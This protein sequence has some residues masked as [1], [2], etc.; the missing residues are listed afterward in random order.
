MSNV[1]TFADISVDT[2]DR[3][4][5][6]PENCVIQFSVSNIAIKQIKLTEIEIPISYYN[7]KNINPNFLTIDFDELDGVGERSAIILPAALV[8]GKVVGYTLDIFLTAIKAAL[9]LAGTYTYT[10]DHSI[11]TN[12]ITITSTGLFNIQF[13]SGTNKLSKIGSLLGYTNMDLSRQNS[14]EA[15]NTLNIDVNNII[16]LD[17]FEIRMPVGSYTGTEFTAAL[18]EILSSE[19]G[20]TF[21]VA[22]DSITNKITITSDTSPYI[23]YFGTGANAPISNIPNTLGFDQLDTN[24][25]MVHTGLN[26]INFAFENYLYL[27]SSTALGVDQGLITSNIRDNNTI[28]RIP[29]SEATDGITF[30][31]NTSQFQVDINNP[32]NIN[33]ID[34]QITFRNNQP[35]DFNGHNWSAKMRILY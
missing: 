17:A 24:S 23:L 31:T 2:R 28:A 3:I 4:S 6:T 18:A 15:P 34:F 20:Q 5:G 33:T 9:D 22:I 14:Y 27:K 12:K 30:Y 13:Q 29:I 26:V 10:V 21:T 16:D 8:G 1:N 25:S 19:G 32:L 35:V 11:I 7:I